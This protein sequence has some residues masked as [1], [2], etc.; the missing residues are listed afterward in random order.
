MR[1]LRCCTEQK[2]TAALEEIGLTAAQGQL[3]GYL[4]HSEKPP[5]PRD[6]ENAFHL[7]HPTVSGLLSRLEQ[8]GFLQLQTDLLADDGTAGQDRR[9]KRIHLLPRASQLDQRIHQIIAENELE[10]VQDFSQ[11]EREQFSR[12]LRRAIQ[13]M[14]GNDYCCP[15]KEDNSQ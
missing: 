3:M 6:V 5:C 15:M 13:N 2:I 9:C 11:E 7:S 14:G 1:V 8:K 10:M 4:I 12:L